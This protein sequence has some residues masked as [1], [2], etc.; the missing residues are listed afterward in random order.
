MTE[1]ML[2]LIK[3]GK[4]VGHE[5]RTTTGSRT[6]LMAIHHKRYITDTGYDVA[7]YLKYKI[8]YIDHDSF[9]PGTKVGG[10]WFFPGD[11]VLSGGIKY[12]IKYSEKNSC[13][14]LENQLT[15]EVELGIWNDIDMKRI[16]TIYDEELK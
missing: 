7:K 3:D 1:L 14:C 8:N 15:S 5:I 10:E 9:D 6:P 11:I 13:F 2:R 12:L 16:G 4:I